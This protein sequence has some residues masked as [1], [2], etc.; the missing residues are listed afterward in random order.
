MSVLEF[1][2]RV[3]A[4]A[5]TSPMTITD[6]EVMLGS[7]FLVCCNVKRVVR[8]VSVDADSIAATGV[9]PSKPA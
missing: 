1:Q 7:T 2:W 6:G 5:A 9:L 8:C 3:L 4:K